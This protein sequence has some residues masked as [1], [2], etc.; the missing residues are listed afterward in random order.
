M[1]IIKNSKIQNDILTFD[2][3]NDNQI[4]KISLANALR[5][6]WIS[7][8]EVVGIDLESI[9]FHENNSIL[10]NEFL[11]D[12]LTLIPIF[13]NKNF[14]Y[15]NIMIQ[16]SKENINELTQSVYVR[17]FECINTVTQEKIKVEDL[18]PYPNILF[19]KCKTN[20]KIHFDAKLKRSTSY[21]EGSVFSPVS[22]CT[23]VFQIDEEETSKM[24]KNMTEA[25]KRK[26]ATEEIQRYYKKNSMDEPAVYQ[27]VIESIGNINVKDIFRLGIEYLMNHLNEIKVEF[28]NK[29][30]EKIKFVKNFENETIFQILFDDENETLGNLLS[31][32]L[33]DDENVFYCGYLIEHPLKKNILLN[34]H[35][36]I[37]YT[38]DNFKK[39]L[40]S[41]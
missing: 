24:M 35:L 27:Y 36:N 19:A 13:S 5:R 26:F 7:N 30:T 33:T 6:V 39:L 22:Q 20:Q 28:D 3:I 1:S 23:Y 18:F 14:D 38:I 29:K 21:K 17:D 40:E 8:I 16:Y 25:E 15:E 9:K 34:L 11:A 41:I 10:N 37:K 31:Q 4:V 2:L 32:Y 12:R